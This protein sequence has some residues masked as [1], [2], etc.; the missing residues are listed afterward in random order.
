VG[1]KAPHDR[2]S[3][4]GIRVETVRMGH[5]PV[6]IDVLGYPLQPATNMAELLVRHR[7]TLGR[8][9]KK[10]RSV[11]AWTRVRWRGGR[12]AS[13][14]ACA[15]RDIIAFTYAQQ[16][17]STVRERVVAEP[18]AEPVVVESNAW[19]CKL[20]DELRSERHGC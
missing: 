18:V 6:I 7:T 1:N 12:A 11:S 5:V 9:R 4:A 8:T 16:S 20:C 3:V 17:L 2:D 19:L 15:A 13:A 14:R 10:R